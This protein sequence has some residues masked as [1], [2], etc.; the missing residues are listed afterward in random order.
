MAQNVCIADRPLNRMGTVATLLLICTAVSAEARIFRESPILSHRVAGGELPPVEDR[1]P[2]NPVV[3]EPVESIGKYGGT[4]RRMA[5]DI[6]D[7]GLNSR[8]GYERLIS[9]DRTGT[10]VIPGVAES[11]E[12][13]DDGKTFTFHL[14][15]GMKWSDGHPFTSADFQFTHYEIE[16]NKEL[17]PTHS[18]WNIIGGKVMD[19]KTPDPY[20]VVISFSRPYGLFPEMLCYH[21]RSWDIYLPKHYLTQFHVNYRDPDELDREA[22]QAGFINW[23]VYFKDRSN[24]EKNPDLPTINAFMPKV[25]FPAPRCLSVRNPY[26]WKVDPEGNQLPYIDAISYTTVFDSN[27]LNLKAQSGEVDFQTRR[28]NAGNYTL[29]MESR[30]QARDPKNHYRVQVDQSTFAIVVYINQYSRDETLRP[31]LQDKRFRVAL[32]VSIDREEISEIVFDGLADPNNGVTTELDTYYRSALDKMHTRYDPKLANQL[33]DEVGLKRGIN[34]VRRLP[35]GEP[36]RQILHIYPSEASVSENLWLLVVEYWRE[37]GLQFIV[38]LEDATLSGMQAR[39]GDSDFWAYHSAGLHWELD[40]IWLAPIAPGSYYAPLYGRYYYSKG[41]AGVKP[42]PEHQQLVHWY[43]Q[44]KSTPSR[45][46]RIEIGQKVL[47]HWADQ[48]YMIGI[49]RKPEVFIISER[50]RNVPARIIQDYRLMTPGY[51]GIEQFYID[52][53]GS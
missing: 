40:G 26:Y 24:L 13:S 22:R 9:W 32:S 25:S 53:A 8:L 41:K 1:L 38:K 19:L 12:M 46:R 50:F 10:K 23:R 18:R 43:T 49:C 6:S 4:W 52:D 37:I 3:V 47:Q 48:C 45:D 20:T 5:Q 17:R 27:V 7:T 29:F 39:N 36:F 34:G 31:I 33:L 21:G 28:I 15:K 14:R 35:S 16:S 2:D 11:W 44:M 51:I 42:P 30:K